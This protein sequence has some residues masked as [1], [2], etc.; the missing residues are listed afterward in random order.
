M[1][2]SIAKQ[3]A[4]SVESTDVGISSLSRRRKELGVSCMRRGCRDAVTDAPR[5]AA[6]SPRYSS[7][8]EVGRVDGQQ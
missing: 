2:G 5:L 3:S 8:R 7:S 6:G 4:E 1:L